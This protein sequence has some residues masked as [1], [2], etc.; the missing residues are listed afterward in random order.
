MLS[1]VQRDFEV[2]KV[3]AREEFWWFWDELFRV[4]K[5]LNTICAIHNGVLKNC[6]YIEQAQSALVQIV[7]NSSELQ[8][9]RVRSE[10]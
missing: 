7:W 1:I 8:G 10:I 4:S 6:F 2:F 5:L 9:A 3:E